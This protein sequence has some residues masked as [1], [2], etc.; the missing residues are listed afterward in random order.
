[1]EARARILLIQPSLEGPG[2]GDGVAAWMIQALCQD[3]DLTVFTWRPIDPEQADR[4]WGTTLSKAKIDW[5][6]PTTTQTRWVDA[7]PFR[8][9]LLQASLLFRWAR[10]L[11][12]FHLRISTLCE[13]S[14][15]N[16]GLQYIHIPWTVHPWTDVSPFWYS[17][18]LSWL[19]HLYQALCW[20]IAGN[21]REGLEQNQTLVN[22]RWTGHIWSRQY[23]SLPQVLNPPAA[24]PTTPTDWM[25]RK[26][27]FLCIGRLAE[28]KR[29]ELILDI[30]SR[31]RVHHPN[32]HLDIVTG[33]TDSAYAREILHRARS[34]NWVTL[35]SKL[36]RSQ[37][38]NLMSQHKYGIHGKAEEHFGMGIAEMTRAGCI[39]FAP[40]GGGQAEILGHREEL[41]Y[42]SQDEAVAKISQILD[43]RDS[44]DELRHFL[45]ERSARYSCQNFETKTKQVVRGL[46]E[47]NSHSE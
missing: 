22:S 46:L 27:G 18:P 29:V 41:L 26:G 14:F 25:S 17:P 3:H 38:S 2:G 1:M 5:R 16:P 20:R 8:H 44:Q 9:D 19:R 13:T 7:I 31:V 35:H 33:G 28:D 15:E 45:Q 30:L 6:H 36:D 40:N 32:L 47:R 4:F 23:S 42:Q 10:Q 24:D 43:S 34:L 39:V 37:L 11:R 21:T 12:G